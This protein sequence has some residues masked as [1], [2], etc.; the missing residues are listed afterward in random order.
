MT[1]SG[2]QVLARA[3]LSPAPTAPGLRQRPRRCPSPPGMPRSRHWTDTG[4][5]AVCSPASPGGLG[6]PWPES[7]PSG[8]TELGCPLLPACAGSAPWGREPGGCAPA[9]RH[10]RS[11][12]LQA[13]LSRGD[14]ERPRTACS[15]L[16]KSRPLHTRDKPVS[17][18]G[19]RLNSHGL[20]WVGGCISAG[21]S[22]WGRRPGFWAVGMGEE[23]PHS[24]L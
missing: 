19:L 14:S 20:G 8:P 24:G 2:A 16:M 18:W 5:S 4:P 22:F 9:C 1:P 7:L 3:S 10:S 15:P 6:R 12:L 11:P 23:T 21:P 17:H 13:Q